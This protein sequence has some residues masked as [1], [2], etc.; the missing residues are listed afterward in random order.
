MDTLTQIILGGSVG[1]AIGYHKLGAK[2]I[3]YGAI[4]GLLPDLDVYATKYLG[5]YGA[6][7]YH[8]H[9]THALWFGP[10]VGTLMGAGLWAL[11]GRV[12]GTLLAWIAV[13][14]LALLTHPL[15]DL[16]TV[17]GTQLLAPFSNYRFTI[18]GV[19]IIDPVY[20]LI[21]SFA[22]LFAFIPPLQP[23]TQQAGI[24]AL[25]VTT[26]YLFYGW[27]QNTKAELI[28]RAELRAQNIQVETVR[29]YTTIF[30]TYLRRVVARDKDGTVYVGFVSTWSPQPIKWSL[31]KQADQTYIDAALATES[32]GVFNWFSSDE[33]VYI[34]D[35]DTNT[36]RLL[37]ARYG[38][39]GASV[40][41][42]WGLQYEILPTA[43]GTIKLS[44]RPSNVSFPREASWENIKQLFR[45]AFGRENTFLNR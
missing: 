45:A 44:D 19:S 11:H 13:M 32:G 41:G 34:H 4:G 2:A 37:D 27:H 18:S 43:D 10:V 17:Y 38:I 3:I 8:R 15:L 33:L 36:L 26:A 6:W 23:Y 30:Q 16:F 40:Y 12:E 25:I 7:K 22:M 1:Q 5:Q 9:I 14:V 35:S 39:P 24:L 29:A 20:T 28:A 31:L 42:W 21:L